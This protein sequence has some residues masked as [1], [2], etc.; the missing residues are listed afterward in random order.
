MSEVT[1]VLDDVKKPWLKENLKEIKN[2]INNHNFSVEDPKKG[3]PI[4]TCI[5]MYKEKIQSD[6]S[7]DKLKLR[8]LVRGDLLNKEMVGDTWSPIASMR[9][10]KYFLAYAT[11]HKA[12]VYQLDF[13]V[14]LLQSKFKN[15]VFVKLDSRYV[16]YFPEYS[17]YFGRALRLLKS[18]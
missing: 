5:D 1:N 3:E 11:K 14:A 4:T 12:I 7:L 18:M 16:D 9:T 2:L 6:G 10:L 13:I 15:R 17:N 8:I